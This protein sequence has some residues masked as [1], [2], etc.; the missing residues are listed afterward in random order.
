M[1]RSLSRHCEL[2]QIVKRMDLIK[3]I[4]II[5]VF[6]NSYTEMDVGK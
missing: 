1:R 3:N 2:K 6:N 5:I 4:L